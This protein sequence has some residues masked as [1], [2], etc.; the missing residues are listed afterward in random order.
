MSPILP[1]LALLL[2]LLLG[3]PAAAVAQVDEA[4]DAAVRYGVLVM[5]HGGGGE[6]DT[7][8]AA[9][10][11]PIAAEM[12]VALALGM[13]DPHTLGA[14]LD[15]LRAAGVQR[16]AVVRM[17]VSGASFMDQTAYLLGLSEEPPRFFIPGHGGHGQPAAHGAGHG[18]D[19]AGHG[20]STPQPIAHGLEVATHVDG[21]IDAPE[22][23]TILT[24]RALASGGDRAAQSVLLIAHGMA[25]A[26]EDAELLE[27]LEGVEKVLASE[28]YAAVRSITL[29]ED[30]PEA[31][32]IA[33]REIRAF[34]SEENARGRRVVV[35]PV[36][37]SGF[38]PYAEVLRGL[39]YVEAEALLP[40]R[41]VSAWVSAKAAAIARA[42]G[43]SRTFE[44]QAS[45]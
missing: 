34:V 14:G 31:R 44:A 20:P 13:A 10:L 41:S 7:E 35:V 36:R 26:E 37:L 27:A 23:L 9:A 38:G 29:R 42:N 32:V 1:R 8:V 12:P 28:P 22:T 25:D 24:E 39:D 17:F 40:H 2:A 15:S 4:P 11:A 43:W 16:V 33:E 30:W 3:L 21:M 18:A 19:G 45:R 5:A 6:W